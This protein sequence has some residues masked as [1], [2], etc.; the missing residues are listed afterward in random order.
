MVHITLISF[1]EMARFLAFLSFYFSCSC[2][3]LTNINDPTNG[4]FVFDQFKHAMSLTSEETQSTLS[5][6][7]VSLEDKRRFEGQTKRKGD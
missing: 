7:F 6:K 4:A 2:L 1:P 3:V 5:S